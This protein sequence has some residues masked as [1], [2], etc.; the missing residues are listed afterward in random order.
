MEPL[1]AGMWFH[2]LP[3]DCRGAGAEYFGELSMSSGD[4]L[5]TSVAS[6]ALLFTVFLLSPWPR[7][8]SPH[9]MSVDQPFISVF[10]AK[11]PG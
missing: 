7:M 4:W 5:L 8:Y 3:W 10:L 2:K 1:G 9:A 11:E 6:T